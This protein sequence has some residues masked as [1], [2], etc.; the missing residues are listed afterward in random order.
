MTVSV[1][2][3]VILL[4]EY[5]VLEEGGLGAAF[6]VQNRVRLQAE[7]AQTLTVEG[8]WPGGSFL[9]TPAAP[10]GESASP[11]V[12]AVV[13]TVTEWRQRQ[14]MGDIP[15][16]RIRIDSSELY[17]ARGRKAGFGSSAAVA[18]ALV[19]AL[20]AGRD[21]AS[22]GLA[23]AA[24]RLAQGGTGSGYDVYC[25]FHG[26]W[27]MFRGGAEP[28]WEERARPADLRLYL[29]PGPGPVATREAI[30]SFL[31][32]KGHESGRASRLIQKSN[33]NVRA[34]LAAGSAQEAAAAFRKGRQT[35][36]DLGDEIG[37]QARIPVP[38][39]VDPE[40]CK[41][42]G[43]GNE[44]GAYLQVPGAPEPPAASGLLLVQAS[45]EGAVWQP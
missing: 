44:L 22:A 7:A 41:A 24:H 23:L 40:L 42:V 27:G 5:A 38:F 10:Q 25:S 36:I 21:D 33:D 45:K 1:P 8:R 11:L 20:R 15:R 26:G 9:W 3:N 37:V 18:V 32:W 29:F 4:G 28:S 6:A 19:I 12:P 17:L 34:F 35:G 13:A 43:A 14:G 31:Q 30:Q 2:G 39:D 16:L